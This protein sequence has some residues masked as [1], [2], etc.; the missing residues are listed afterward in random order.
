MALGKGDAA[1]MID[2]TAFLSRCTK[3]LGNSQTAI[4]LAGKK[5]TTTRIFSVLRGRGVLP[6]FSLGRGGADAHR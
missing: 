4:R 6:P 1:E 5:E 2:L 3:S